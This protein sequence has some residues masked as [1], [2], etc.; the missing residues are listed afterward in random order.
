VKTNYGCFIPDIVRWVGYR[1][2]TWR[3]SRR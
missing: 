3:W 1:W 2:Y